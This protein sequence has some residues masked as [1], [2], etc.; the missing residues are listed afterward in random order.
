MCNTALLLPKFLTSINNF[1]HSVHLG[2]YYYNIKNIYIKLLKLL[3]I[4][5][6]NIN[7]CF[8]TTI[9]IYLYSKFELYT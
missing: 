5:A 7:Q 3:P 1:L 8:L 2:I 9:V 4:D 6:Y